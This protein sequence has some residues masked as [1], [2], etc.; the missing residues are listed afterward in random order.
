MSSD[1]EL[2]AA[3]TAGDRAAGG[4]LVDRHLR[5]I[6]RFFANK[7]WD[8]DDAEELVGTTFELCA[9]TLG[10]F[11]GESSF[12]T[13]LFGLAHNVLRNHIRRRR[14]EI[15]EIDLESSAVRDL[16]PSPRTAAARRREQALLLQALRAIP[17]EHQ[18]VLELVYFEGLSRTEIAAALELP[19]G[20]VASRLRRADELLRQ[21]LR[22]QA[23]D[24]AHFHATHDGLA[25]WAEQLREQLGRADG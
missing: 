8:G 13:F 4:R 23:H 15:G 14:P 25:Q 17:L 2:Y 11:R 12:R 18:I 20:T 22:R 5:S 10:S 16:G 6:A 24:A 9:R 1:E 19:A 7:I 21:Q 3:W